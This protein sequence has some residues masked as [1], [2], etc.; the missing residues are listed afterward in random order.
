LRKALIRIAIIGS[1][2]SLMKRNIPRSYGN[3]LQIEQP[4]NSLPEM[5]TASP[6]R[7]ICSSL[8]A[9]YFV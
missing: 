9:K 2:F 7:A 3:F 4:L 1:F 8:D 5:Q 6:H